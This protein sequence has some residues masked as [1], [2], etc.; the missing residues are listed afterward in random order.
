VK[1][2]HFA[3][4]VAEPEAVAQW[5]CSHLG[6][7]VARSYEEPVSCRFLADET[8]VVMLEVYYN[9]SIEVP[10][11]AEMDPLILHLAFVCADV[12]STAERLVTEGATVVV[13]PDVLPNGDELAMLRDPWGMAIQL[14][15]R[16]VPMV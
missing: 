10:P 12:S 15:K 9:P 4:Q 16:S 1:I 3:Y 8:G 13:P 6:F 5:Y 11:Y 14:C 2:E 7:K